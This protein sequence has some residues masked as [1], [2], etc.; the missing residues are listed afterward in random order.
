MTIVS[1]LITD[2]YRQ[3]NLL[4]IGTEPTTAQNTEALRYLNRILKSVYGNEAGE[5]LQAFPIGRKDINRPSGYP[6]YDTTPPADWFVPKN[7]RL[8]CNLEQTA[9]VYLHP[10]PDDGSR[11]AVNDVAGNFATY[12]FTVH[13]NGRLIEGQESIVLNTDD[14]KREWFY[15]DDLNSWMRYAEIDADDEFPFPIEFDDY[16][17]TLLAVR[18][19]P[20]Y[21]VQLDAQSNLMMAR[22]L[23]QLRARY[24]QHIQVGSE[25]GLVKM[26]KTVGERWYNDWWDYYG[27][28]TAAFNTGYPYG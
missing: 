26:P 9:Q 27:D 4:A 18:L 20:S 8:M 17:I 7:Q 14:L 19:N 13:G 1:Q 22:S 23:R 11:F 24:A 6:W 28:T 5:Q 21:G 15:R 16:F 10:I 25:L 12:N 2:A 3:S